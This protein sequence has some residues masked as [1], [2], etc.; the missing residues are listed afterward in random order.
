[1]I[2]DRVKNILLTPKQ[3][4]PV[5]ESELTTPGDLYKGYVIPLAALSAVLSFIRM[6]LIGTSAPYM[7]NIRIPV[8]NGL[9][10]AVVTFVF[11]LLGLYLV[12]LIID[13]LAPTFGGVRDRRQALKTAAYAFTPAWLAAVFG[14]LPGGLSHLLGFIAGLYGIYLLYLGLPIVMKGPR[15]RAVGYTATVVVCTILVGLVFGALMAT[16]GGFSGMTGRYGP[17]GSMHG[18]GAQTEEVRQARAAAMAGNIIG[19]V[20]GTDEKGKE[21]LSKAMAQMAAAGRQIEQQQKGINGGAVDT[22]NVGAQGASNANAAANSVA[23]TAQL[24]SAV[25]GALGG[26]HRVDPV[27]FRTLKGMLPDSV[28]GMQ[29]TGS[30]GANEQ[31]LGVKTSNATADYQGTGDARLHIKISDISGVSGLLGVAGAL[32][33]KTDSESDAGF[34]KDTTIGGR[35]FHEKFQNAGKHGELTTIVSQRFEVDVTG[36]GADVSALEKAAGSID[37]AHLESMKN[38]GAQSR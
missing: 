33:Q 11:S 16:V 14:L 23:A 35:E 17:Y 8:T 15:E 7:D 5:I 9:E 3:E 32:G 19:N 21:G 29:R 10:Y 13:G 31:A 12:A 25:G 38:Q 28:A 24:A 18:L 1:M 2:I 27:D 4:W 30:A 20:L 26:D 6:S 36:E 22:A 37:F 34:E